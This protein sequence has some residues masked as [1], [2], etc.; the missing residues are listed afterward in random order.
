MVNDECWM[1][2]KEVWRFVYLR[3]TSDKNNHHFLK[4]GKAKGRN[5]SPC[6]IRTL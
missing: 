4:N 5:L 2:N 1:M 3:W 6:L